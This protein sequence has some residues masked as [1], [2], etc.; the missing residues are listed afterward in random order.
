MMAIEKR[1]AFIGSRDLEEVPKASVKAFMDAVTYYAPKGYVMRTGAAPGA[2]QLAAYK[3]LK[4]GGTVEFYVPWVAFEQRWLY[5][6]RLKFGDRVAGNIG[7]SEEGI[8][9]VYEHHPNPH[10]LREYPLKLLARNYDIVKDCKL[11]IAI[12]R[13]PELGGTSQAMRVARALSIR[14]INASTEEGVNQIK[15]LLG[16]E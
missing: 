14:V 13:P 12:P 15:E 6:M 2:D 4:L 5:E 8:K 3:F 9:S 11:V 1:V 10:S 7:P 16:Q